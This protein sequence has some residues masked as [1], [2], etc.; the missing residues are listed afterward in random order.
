[1]VGY[2]VSFM[3]GGIVGFAAAAVLAAGKDEHY[4]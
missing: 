2:I 1:M 3:C 4:E